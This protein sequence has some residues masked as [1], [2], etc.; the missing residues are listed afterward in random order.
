MKKF[1][2]GVLTLVLFCVA[3][4]SFA[5]KKYIKN[6]FVYISINDKH[7]HVSGCSLTDTNAL[8]VQLVEAKK[9]FL[10]CSQCSFSRFGQYIAVEKKR[11]KNAKI[12]LSSSG[13]QYYYDHI[14]RKIFLSEN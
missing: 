10:P 8:K 2:T 4:L 12:L 7:F 1:T 5:Q 6:N 13:I 3:P 11:D 9:Q 14:G